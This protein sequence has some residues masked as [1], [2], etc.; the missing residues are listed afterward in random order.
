MEIA[1]NHYKFK[2]K[3]FNFILVF[4]LLLICLN[5]CEPPV[6]VTFENQR[7]QDI[8]LLVA[9]VEDN[10]LI[11]EFSNYGIISANTSKTIYITFL[12]PNWVNRIEIVDITGKVV[13]SHDYKMEDLEKIGWKIIISP[14]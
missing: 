9:N 7:N 5:A 10:H 13:F 8:K 11:S 6:K 14:P 1:M 2:Y 3:P 4:I 12:G